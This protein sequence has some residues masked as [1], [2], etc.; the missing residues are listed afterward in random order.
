MRKFKN[1]TEKEFFKQR[2]RIQRQINRLHHRGFF[3][4]ALE[5][6]LPK[7]PKNITKKDVAKI[8]KIK[9]K[10]LI[11]LAEHYGTYNK[12]F[13][14]TIIDTSGKIGQRVEKR[15]KKNLRNAKKLGLSTDW[16]DKL[17]KNLTRLYSILPTTASTTV[18]DTLE[19]IISS[20]SDK[21]GKEVLDTLVMSVLNEHVSIDEV[22]DFFENPKVKKE[23]TIML[24]RT[25]YKD[26]EEAEGDYFNSIIKDKFSEGWYT[27]SPEDEEM[28]DEELKEYVES[29]LNSF[30]S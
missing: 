8:A 20:F 24:E 29:I 28:T 4:G 18:V 25:A 15:M 9:S 12:D 13:D 2:G 10:D 14:K 26:Y 16:Y 7:I 17:S 11:N 1:D 22:N 27:P 5:S 19:K 6:A 21:G 30:K 23:L 3:G